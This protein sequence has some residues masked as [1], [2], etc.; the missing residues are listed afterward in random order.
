[1]D[2]IHGGG[3]YADGIFVPEKNL[4]IRCEGEM[5]YVAEGPLEQFTTSL[6]GG[7]ERAP[8]I[9]KEIEIPEAVVDCAQTLIDARNAFSKMVQ[10]LWREK[11]LPQ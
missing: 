3:E 7:E 1:M 2:L 4:L 6:E 10:E 8:K 11:G 5:A 9:S